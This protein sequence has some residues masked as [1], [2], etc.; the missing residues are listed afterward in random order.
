MKLFQIEEPDG[1]PADPDAPGAAVGIDATGRLAEVGFAVGGNAVIFADREG[2]Q[3][4]IPVPPLDA[5][6]DAWRELF[7][8]TRIRAERNLGR[9]VT[10]AVLGLARQPDEAAIAIL[11]GAA[12]AAGLELLMVV[13]CGT[14][15]RAAAGSPALTLASLAEDTAPRPQNL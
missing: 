9:P 3:R 13:Q 2:Y 5:P 1:S 7:E 6:T 14:L 15:D 11:K 12:A 10:H 8:W 4:D